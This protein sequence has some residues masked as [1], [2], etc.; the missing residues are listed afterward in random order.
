MLD[1][2]IHRSHVFNL[3][4]ESMRKKEVKRLDSF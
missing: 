4:G 3:E 2:I 1:R